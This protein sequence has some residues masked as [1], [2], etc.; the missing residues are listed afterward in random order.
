MTTMQEV[1]DRAGV[2]IATVSYVV[3]GTKAVTPATRAKI[4]AAMA[5]LNFQRNRAARALAIRRTQNLALVYPSL[6]R[7]LGTTSLE[8][9][10]SAA[11]AANRSDYH[12]TLWP[13]SNDAVGLTE[14]LSAGLVDGVLLM[15]VLLEDP[16]VTALR[17]AGTPFAMIGRTSDPSG[18]LYVDIDFDATVSGALDHLE[19]LGHR[20]V[21]LIGEEGGSGDLPG[22]GPQVRTD[23]AFAR[24]VAERGLRSIT[25][26][27]EQTASAGADITQALLAEHPDVTAILVRNEQATL[28][29]M[30]G[31]RQAGLRVPEDVSVIAL[32]TTGEIST[33]SSPA[34]TMMQSPGEELGRLGVELLVDHLE[35]GERTP[36]QLVPCTFL[37]GASIAP[38]R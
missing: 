1:A 31:V 23:E 12:L 6:E 22:Y 20:H 32:G 38:A 33:M 14:L 10:T 34:L 15:E 16:R 24:F 26:G 9:L 18:E 4:E 30:V 17:A 19:S 36:P 11:T 3:N 8:F 27:C 5:A 13:I 37:P 25:V 21:A 29:V 2:S 7:R 35:S 28:G